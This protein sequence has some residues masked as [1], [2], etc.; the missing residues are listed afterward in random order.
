[1]N[2][3]VE[4]HRQLPGYVDHERDVTIERWDGII[5]WRTFI[6]G[7]RTPTDT[8]TFEVA[9]RTRRRNRARISATSSL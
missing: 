7:D 5:T 3:Q 9:E 1:M 2:A 8:M 4:T 6:N